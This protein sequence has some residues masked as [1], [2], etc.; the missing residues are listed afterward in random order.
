MDR[1]GLNKIK[2]TEEDRIKH[3]GPNRTKVDGIEPNK[4]KW[5]DVDRIGPYQTEKQNWTKWTEQGRMR[6]KWT[7]LNI[8]DQIGP[9]C[10]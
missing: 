4:T 7:E 2:W 9:K 10:T 1:S 6:P 8:I 3:N 5:T